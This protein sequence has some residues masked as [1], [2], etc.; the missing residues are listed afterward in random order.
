MTGRR[1]GLT[2]PS[3]GRG[4]RLV[5]LLR[6]AP[7]CG[8]ETRVDG[9]TFTTPGVEPIPLRTDDTELD[10]I[11]AGPAYVDGFTLPT[12]ADLG[13]TPG[14]HERNV[15]LPG[16]GLGPACEAAAWLCEAQLQVDELVL[17]TPGVDAQRTPEIDLEGSVFAGAGADP[18]LG[19]TQTLGPY[20]VP[21]DGRLATLCPDGCDAPATPTVWVRVQHERELRVDE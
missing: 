9:T 14:S 11:D 18:R 15:T 12:E 5:D 3:L 6:D 21:Q 2:V 4:E 7:A 1:P 19:D 20:D 16:A 8:N 10:R 13:E 17:E